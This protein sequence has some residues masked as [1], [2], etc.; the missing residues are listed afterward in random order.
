MIWGHYHCSAS[1]V[2]S[3]VGYVVKKRIFPE[4]FSTHR[5]S[6][7]LLFFSSRIPE[8]MCF[9]AF[10]SHKS[11]DVITSFKDHTDIA[12]HNGWK[13]WQRWED[14]CYQFMK[15]S[16]ETLKH[17]GGSMVSLVL[18]E[19]I[20]LVWLFCFM[21]SFLILLFYCSLLHKYH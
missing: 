6:P 8:L 20:W 15:G 3:Y 16:F 18:D 13:Y 14:I 7:K 10:L 19:N 11:Y 12:L 1:L 21:C 2:K 9:A 5:K 4:V 17:N